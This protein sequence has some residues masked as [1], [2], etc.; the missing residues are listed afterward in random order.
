LLDV[1]LAVF[2]FLLIM[3]IC[4]HATPNPEPGAFSGNF[5]DSPSPAD[6]PLGHARI[7]KKED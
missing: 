3:D 6:F 7:N 4:N 5:H 2:V 1:G